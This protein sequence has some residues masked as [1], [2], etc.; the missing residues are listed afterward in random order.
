MKGDLGCDGTFDSSDA[1][2]ECAPTTAA[3]AAVDQDGGDDPFASINVGAHSAPAFADLDGDGLADLVLG[4]GTSGALTYY[5]NV[6]SSTT[7]R[8]H[9]DEDGLF[10]GGARH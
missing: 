7:A 10:A 1:I 3:P 4:K 8:F 9:A 6:G 2:C 5:K